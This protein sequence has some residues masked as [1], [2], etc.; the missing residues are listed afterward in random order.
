MD[1]NICSSV[2]EP[3][4]LVAIRQMTPL[5]FQNLLDAACDTLI[6]S[7]GPEAG[8][9][10]SIDPLIG[11]LQRERHDDGVTF[12]MIGRLKAGRFRQFDVTVRGLY[13]VDGVSFTGIE[14]HRPWA[15]A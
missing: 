13:T 11:S 3:A 10:M 6:E 4:A 5:C 8:T 15:N 7:A 12:S 2:V 9:S 1:L 14:R